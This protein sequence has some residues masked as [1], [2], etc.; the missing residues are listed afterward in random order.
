MG[1]SELGTV[2]TGDSGH[3]QDVAEWASSGDMMW[4]NLAWR[5]LDRSE[6]DRVALHVDIRWL[7]VRGA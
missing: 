7:T 5:P 1:L 6:H 3:A 2:G 4:P